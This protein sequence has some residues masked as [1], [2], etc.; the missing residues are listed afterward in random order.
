MFRNMISKGREVEREEEGGSEVDEDE[1]RS[2][3]TVTAGDDGD[4]RE[5]REREHGRKRVGE[6][7]IEERRHGLLD[8]PRTPETGAT[9]GMNMHDFR[10][11]DNED[12][13]CGVHDPDLLSATTASSPPAVRPSSPPLSRQQNTD[14][15]TTHPTTLADQLENALVVSRGLQAQ[16][17]APQITIQLLEAKVVVLDHPFTSEHRTVVNLSFKFTHHL[18][19]STSSP[20]LK[21]LTEW[22]R[23]V[24]MDLGGVRRRSAGDWTVPARNG[25]IT[26]AGGS[27]ELVT[28]RRG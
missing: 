20:T 10:D 24:K 8:Q 14:N 19:P 5:E 12:A 9:L 11:E 22:Q 2:V 17:Y 27:T 16:K 6:E 23:G 4:V 7:E 15:L 25:R 1:T 18:Q 21:L 28:S 26:C 13:R 3:A